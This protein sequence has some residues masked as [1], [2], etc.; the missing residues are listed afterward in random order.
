MKKTFKKLTTLALTGLLT[1]TPLL[2]HT[3]L[4]RAQPITQTTIKTTTPYTTPQT[5]NPSYIT[6]SAQVGGL[7]ITRNRCD[8]ISSF[9][10]EDRFLLE[11]RLYFAG[12]LFD[13]YVG[14][15]FHIGLRR[16]GIRE[17]WF[18]PERVRESSWVGLAP[19]I[20]PGFEGYSNIN[21]NQTSNLNPFLNSSP[22]TNPNLRFNLNT[23]HN[24]NT[25]V[26]TSLNPNANPNTNTN[27]RV[28]RPFIFYS[29]SYNGNIFVT[30]Y[31]P[32]TF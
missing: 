20:I 7:R 3:T 17:I 18:E 24:T 5:P 26:E 10:P 6:L 2:N 11:G 23:N 12:E 25:N 4:F 30:I 27:P 31:N 15:S 28:T 14:S 19:S 13:K 32:E 16:N 21:H 29:H 9:R 22:N 8:F 1:A